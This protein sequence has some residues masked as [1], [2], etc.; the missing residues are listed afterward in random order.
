MKSLPVLFLLTSFAAHAGLY[1]KTEG[2]IIDVLQADGFLCNE[3]FFTEGQVCFTG[4]RAEV[5]AIINSDAFQRNF[6]GTDGEFI[7]NARFKGQY[8]ISYEYV[9]DGNGES[10]KMTLKRCRPGFFK[11]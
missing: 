6:S 3:E 10:E 4:K 1:C 7:H 11:I 9:D 5:I 2:R 8:D